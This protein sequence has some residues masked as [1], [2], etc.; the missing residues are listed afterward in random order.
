MHG[1]LDQWMIVHIKSGFRSDPQDEISRTR[2]LVLVRLTSAVMKYHDQFGEERL[3]SAYASTPQLIIEGNQ[4]RTN[5][6]GTW[7]QELTQKPRRR[8]AYWLAPHSL[9]SL[10]AYRTKTSS[11]LSLHPQITN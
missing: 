2:F 9:L 7:R 10:L 1:I 11:G 5:R 6:T 3:Y 8:A 4:N